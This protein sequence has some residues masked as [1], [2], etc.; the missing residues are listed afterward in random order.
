MKC[1]QSLFY[2]PSR[3]TLRVFEF[4]RNVSLFDRSIATPSV[5][6]IHIPNISDIQLNHFRIDMSS[7]NPKILLLVDGSPDGLLEEI[8]PAFLD[9]LRKQF[10]TEDINFKRTKSLSLSQSRPA[11]ILATNGSIAQSRYRT[12][13]NE[14]VSF[15]NDGGTL[16]CCCNFAS[17]CRPLDFNTFMAAF[18][19]PWKSGD[20][21]RS[22][23]V[24]NQ[25]F[26]D[27]FGPDRFGKLATSYSMKA[28]HVSRA[29]SAA[30]V[31][32]PDSASRTES[33]VFP[34][35]TVDQAQAPIV[36]GKCGKGELGYLGDVNG[37]KETAGLLLIMIG[38]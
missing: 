20:Y 16:I 18:D 29:S 5:T 13:R 24:L 4:T 7:P 32:G 31:Y 30:M 12:L 2:P 27:R 38:M 22:T 9:A 37:E 3:P 26:K 8:F 21:H 14:L 11:V 23:F 19:L 36:L 17:F 6:L 34:S 33:M 28:N 35:S 15:V 10:Q 1:V 25:A